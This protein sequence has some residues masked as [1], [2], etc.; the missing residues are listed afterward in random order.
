MPHGWG[1]GQPGTRPGVANPTPGVNTNVLAPPDLPDEPS[2]N[3]ALN[4]IP[5]SVS[6]LAR[7]SAHP[8]G[9]STSPVAVTVMS[10]CA[11]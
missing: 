4:G 2:D 1:H 3:R 11:S 8:A 10:G 5:V 7:W 9:V 6:A